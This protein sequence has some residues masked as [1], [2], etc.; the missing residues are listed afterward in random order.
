[1]AAGSSMQSERIEPTWEEPI[2][3]E[4]DEAIFDQW[5]RGCLLY[6]ESKQHQQRVKQT[7]R[8]ISD[9]LTIEPKTRIAWSAGKDSTAMTHLALSMGAQGEVFSI[10]DDLD[11][12]GEEDY[13][14]RL[15][16]AW[17]ALDRLVVLHPPVS[18]WE[19]LKQINPDVRDD[20]HARTSEFSKVGFYDVIDEYNARHPVQAT[21][22]GLRAAESRGRRLNRKIRGATYQKK[23]G[24]IISQPLCDWE[25]RD[26]YA[27]L[28]AHDIELLPVYHCVRLVKSPDL[29]RKSWWLPGASSSFGGM[30]WLRTYYPSLYMR[31]VME[32]PEAATMG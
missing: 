14:R 9:V 5:R 27:Y 2:L 29:V 4:E 32:F 6:A 10:K 22:L 1:M 31:L 13:V 19:L 12:P 20:L 18:L 17:G 26:V 28:F 7:Q 16:A 23:D 30:V 3:T 24:H 21:M 15:A 11:Y 25:G 8:H